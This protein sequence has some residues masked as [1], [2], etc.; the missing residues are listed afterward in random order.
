MVLRFRVLSIAGLDGDGGGCGG[1][2][3]IAAAAAAVAN[4]GGWLLDVLLPCNSKVV[5]LLCFVG[6]RSPNGAPQLQTRSITATKLVLL[7]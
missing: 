7:G 6:T 4:F 2:V 5:F 1:A 3:A